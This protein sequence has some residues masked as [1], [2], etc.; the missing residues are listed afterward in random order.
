[1]SLSGPVVVAIFFSVVFLFFLGSCFLGLPLVVQFVVAVYSLTSSVVVYGAQMGRYIGVHFIS[2][3]FH[4]TIFPIF[5]IISL[6]GGCLVGF[7]QR[8]L[9]L[10]HSVAWSL[11]GKVLQ[12]Y[13]TIPPSNGL[14]GPIICA[15]R[16][17]PISSAPFFIGHDFYYYFCTSFIVSSSFCNEERFKD[18]YRESDYDKDGFH[19]CKC[20]WSPL[21]KCFHLFGYFMSIGCLLLPGYYSTQI[22]VPLMGGLLFLVMIVNIPVGFLAVLIAFPYYTS[23]LYTSLPIALE[24]LGSL[25]GSFLAQLIG[26]LVYSI[27]CF[28]LDCQIIGKSNKGVLSPSRLCLQLLKGGI[29][30]T[31]PSEVYMNA[32][33]DDIVMG[34]PK[35]SLF[36]DS[37]MRPSPTPREIKEDKTIVSSNPLEVSL[38]EEP[39]IIA[40]DQDQVGVWQFYKKTGLITHVE[41]FSTPS[42]NSQPF[43][44]EPILSLSPE[45]CGLD[46]NAALHTGLCL[47]CEKDWNSHNSTHVCANGTRGSWQLSS[48]PSSSTTS[49]QSSQQSNMKRLLEYFRSNHGTSEYSVKCVGEVT[50]T[51]LPMWIKQ[52]EID[53][54]KECVTTK[55]EDEKSRSELIQLETKKTR[56][57]RTLIALNEKEK[58]DEEVISIIGSSRTSNNSFGTN[59]IESISGLCESKNI[60]SNESSNRSER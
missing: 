11:C 19:K 10:I 29:T 23:P 18:H 3:V 60:D 56:L 12:K 5:L 8:I 2:A 32:I 51:K 24:R 1:M 49:S 33:T 53:A 34:R 59:S 4:V 15:A 22:G 46:C 9:R 44:L 20:C 50:D 30:S 37:Q 41:N 13:I 54:L 57:E 16:V 47:R 6:F 14:G 27:C 42:A 17:P 26:W 55:Q 25:F 35:E 28:P 21:Q 52:L 36:L 43:K 38:D 58:K 39:V 40:V 48:L 45:G 31:L 7:L